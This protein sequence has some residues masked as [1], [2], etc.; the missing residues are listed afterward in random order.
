MIDMSPA[1]DMCGSTPAQKWDDH[2]HYVLCARCSLKYMTWPCPDCAEVL[3]G[4]R[5][6]EG[7][8]CRSCETTRVWL[9]LPR[10]TQDEVHRVIA[11]QNAVKAVAWVRELVGC[12]TSEAMVLLDRLRSRS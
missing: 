11:E 5:A 9:A 4:V 8:R 12:E 7:T 1:C 10:D 6:D 3:H 2:A